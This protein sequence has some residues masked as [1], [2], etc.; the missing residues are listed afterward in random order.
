MGIINISG[1]AFTPLNQLDDLKVK[2]K[3]F[4]NEL[5]L[6]GSIL[7]SEEGINVF[8]AGR[9]E[10][11]TDFH[12]ALPRFGLPLIEF[13]KSVSKTV[14]FKKLLVRI[15]P[16]IITTRRL[17]ITPQSHPAPHLAPKTLKAWLDEGKEVILLDTRNDYEVHLG[18]FASAMD[19]N[20]K[21][22]HEFPE[23]IEQ[24]DPKLK[25]K[26]IVTYCTGGIRCEK[27]APILIEA[28]FEEVY[29]LEGGILN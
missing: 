9:A 17:D 20:I 24:L 22:F 8:L 2:L 6:K 1:Y 21:S 15:K 3:D 5:A 26:P 29:Q 11:I 19:C 14:P 16:E 4:C 23:A 10:A 12:A 7:L 28:G 13:K 27:A 18:K 25:K